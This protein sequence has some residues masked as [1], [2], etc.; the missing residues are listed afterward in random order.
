MQIP[1]HKK[2]LDIKLYETQNEDLVKYLEKN[3]IFPI[4]DYDNVYYFVDCKILREVIK[5]FKGRT[6]KN[7]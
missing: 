6:I 7:E 3:D 2:N 1:T 4:N 5:K